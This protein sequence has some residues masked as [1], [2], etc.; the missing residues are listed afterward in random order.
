MSAAGGQQ[1]EPAIWQQLPQSAAH[2]V[3][4]HL[5]PILAWCSTGASTAEWAVTGVW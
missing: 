2:A 5:S 4:T 3:D 1:P